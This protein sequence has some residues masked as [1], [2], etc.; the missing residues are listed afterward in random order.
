MPYIEEICVAGKITEVRRYYTLRYHIRGETRKPR[1]KLTTEQ[2]A[3]VNLKKAERELRRIL[4]A[5]FSDEAGDMLVTLSYKKDLRP[6][7]SKEMQEHMA[8]YLRKLRRAFAKEGKELKYVYVKELGPKGAAHIHMVMSHC[9]LKVIRKCW[10]HGQID[11]KLLWTDGQYASIAAY[12]VKYS[13]KTEETEGVLVGKRYYCSR[14][15]TRPVPVKTIIT[16][17]NQFRKVPNVRKGYYLETDSLQH[18]IN[19]MGYEYM[20]YSLHRI[21]QTERKDE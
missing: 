2:Q 17:S 4:N 11:A 10:K 16:R 20:S 12:F 7:D 1:E 14:N 21:G 18:G 19:E 5:T 15:V 13:R 9:D 3:V 8:E 6:R